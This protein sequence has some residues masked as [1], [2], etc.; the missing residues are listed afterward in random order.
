MTVNDAE[1]SLL[2]SAE[3]FG[4]SFKVEGAEV[5]LEEAL[6]PTPHLQCEEVRS[7]FADVDESILFPASAGLSSQP[8]VAT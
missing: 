4:A 6:P 2:I 5:E 8:V 1:D 7:A 3:V